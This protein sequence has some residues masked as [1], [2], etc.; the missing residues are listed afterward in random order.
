MQLSLSYKTVSAHRPMIISSTLIFLVVCV[1]LSLVTG[2]YAISVPEVWSILGTKIGLPMQH[3]AEEKMAVFWTIRF[4]RVL[5]GVL[6]GGSLAVAGACLQGLFRNPLVEPAIIGVS[7]GSAL[8]AVII[9]VFSSSIGWQLRSLFGAFALPLAAFFGGL[10][11]TFLA[12]RLASKSGKTDISILILAGVAINALS[13]ALIGLVIYYGDDNAIRNFTFWSLGSLGGASWNKLYIVGSFII[14][15]TIVMMSF[16]KFLNALAVGESEAFHMGIHVQKV[17]YL[18]LFF[19]ALAVGAGVSV[20]GA[21]GFVGLV[22]PHLVRMMLGSDHRTLLPVAFLLGA[23]LML[24]SDII[25]RLI[26][27]P[28]ELSIGIITALIGA[29]FFI[30]ILLNFKRQRI[31]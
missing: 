12:Y 4:P 3:V 7:S 8:F 19:S 23:I 14:I 29:P 16:P 1:L 5:L 30:S 6:V 10:L 11:N 22:V 20:T 31:L 2:A 24:V 9:I 28:A 27:A 13:A 21:I 18:V 26:V 17:K 25:S 15:S